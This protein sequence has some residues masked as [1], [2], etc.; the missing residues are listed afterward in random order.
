MKTIYSFLFLL[1]FFAI[2][3]EAQ[4]VNYE[5]EQPFPNVSIT[6]LLGLEAPVNGSTY[7]YLLSQPGQI[8][9][10]DIAAESPQ[11]EVWLDISGRLISGGER[12]LLGLAFHPEFEQ[13]GRFYVNYTASSPLRTVISRFT[14]DEDGNG[15][16]N[17]EEVLL[18]FNQPFANHNGGQISFGPDGFLYIASGDGGSGGDPQNH[19][20]NPQTLLGAM[21]RIDVDNINVGLA[22][23]IPEDNPFVGSP[24]G[25]NE[26][27]A[28][29]LRNPWRF[30]FDR[31]SGVLWTGDVGQNAWEAIHTIENGLNYGWNILEG[32][33]CYPAGTNCD[34]TGLELPVFEYNHNQGDRSITG[35]YVYRGS[36]NPSLF[37][38]YIYGDFI[39]G[40]IWALDYDLENEE[41]ISNTELINTPFNISSFGEDA[42]GEI[43]VLSYGN[44]RIYRF[45]PEVDEP[46]IPEVP[47]I[48]SP[49]NGD[50][51]TSLHTV[52]WTP[53]ELAESYRIQISS[54][55]EFESPEIDE[56]VTEEEFTSDML[57]DGWYYVRVNAKNEAGVSDFSEVINYE[58]RFPVSVDPEDELPKV[59]ALHGAYPNPFNPSAQI[60]FS[61]PES[62]NVR[63]QVY[64]SDGRLVSTITD[65]HFSAG[66]H[67]V[68]MNADALASGVYLVRGIMGNTTDV[69]KVT[70]VK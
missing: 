42:N 49:E 23:A 39:S 28:W 68:T 69:L 14:A 66:R 32:S 12:G 1:A 13:N 9:R 27:Y 64:T 50:L 25:A 45:V 61:I 51:V 67:Q 47:E 17:S 58:V 20:Q 5:L 30:S 4:E 19:G 2:Q 21:L 59:F 7:I 33:N 10:L 16:P 55:S 18:E 40:R 43:Y 37:G 6:Q 22:Y 26:I 48:T 63:L 3:A 52:M 8:Y 15:D 70:V 62:G 53:S 46:E 38:K 41:F 36:A 24:D 34:P 65:Q 57:P 60:S 35:G 11:A 54:N 44:G 56:M 31:E 29:G